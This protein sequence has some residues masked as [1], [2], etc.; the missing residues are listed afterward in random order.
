M[1]CWNL[2]VSDHGNNLDDREHKFG[3][4]ITFDAKHVDTDDQNEKY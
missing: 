2:H 3:F 4:T 1:G